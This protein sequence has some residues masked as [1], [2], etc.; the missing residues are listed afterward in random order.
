M[1]QAS[2]KNCSETVCDTFGSLSSV[3]TYVCSNWAVAEETNFICK[4]LNKTKHKA[5][6]MRERGGERGG[7]KR[8]ASIS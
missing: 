1:N 3:L 6:Q 8:H 2:N 4:A 5:E 7:H